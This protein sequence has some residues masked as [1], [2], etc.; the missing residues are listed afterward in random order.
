MKKHKKELNFKSYR[1][2]EKLDWDNLCAEN[3]LSPLNL[4]KKK[5]MELHNS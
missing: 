4:K 2:F 5:K 1:Q 3:F